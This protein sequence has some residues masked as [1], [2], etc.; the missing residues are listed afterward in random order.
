MKYST[1]YNDCLGCSDADSV[2]NYLL[3]NLKPSNNLWSYFVNW[4]KVYSN[5]KDIEISLNILNYLIG[6]EDF[7]NEFRR[8]IQ[9]E[10]RVISVLPALAVSREKKFNILVDYQS[11]VLRYENYD[12]S[13]TKPTENDIEKYIYFVDKTG[14]KNLI[15]SNRIKSLV[16]YMIGVESGLDSNARKNR[17][18]TAMEN[19]VEVF[20][21]DVCQKKEG[22][23]YLAQAD[24]KKIKEQFN[25]DVPV[26]KSSRIYD[27]VVRTLNSL[28]I[29][30]VNFYGDGGSKLKSTAGEYRNLYDVLNHQFPFIW[31]TDGMGWKSTHLPLR[32]TFEHNDCILSLAMLERGILEQIL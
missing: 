12:F 24:A 29:I 20:I 19:I 4:D 17:G 6:K 5:V 21:K 8:L 13:I 25:I 30:E 16:D 32:E 18:G 22:Y 27:F 23:E 7:D 15:Q 9:E 11:K 14:L 26:D 10:P 2:F 1:I 28:V 31:I 3:D